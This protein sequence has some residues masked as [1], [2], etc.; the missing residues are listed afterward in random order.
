MSAKF[1]LFL[2]LS[3]A[4]ILEESIGGAYFVLLVILAW[5]TIRPPREVLGTAFLAGL[6]LDL[7]SNAPFG[8]HSIIFLFFSFL[9]FLV[10][11]K[12]ALMGGSI[13][14]LPLVFLFTGFHQSFLDLF[15]TKKVIFSFDLHQAVINTLLLTLVLKIL[16]WLKERVI[17]EDSI[18][19]KFGL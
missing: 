14:L 1:C 13:F 6:L 10:F 2:L 15:W 7:F 11:K 9:T 19:L 3:S 5:L 18:Q 16:F 12:V 17:I 8:S 4:L